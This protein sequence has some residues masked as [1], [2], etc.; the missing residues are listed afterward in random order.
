MPNHVQTAWPLTLAAALGD[1]SLARGLLHEGRSWLDRA[2]A[3]HPA[4]QRLRAA[5][6]RHLGALLYED[7]DL[8]HAEAVLGEAAEA[9]DAAGDATLRARIE[10]LLAYIRITLGGSNAAAFDQIQAARAVL[11]AAGDLAGLA[12]AWF[13][14]CHA[15]EGGSGDWAANEEAYQRALAYARQSGHHHV[16]VRASVYI[17]IVLS[18]APVRADQTIARL[19]QLLRDAGGDL[20]AEAHLLMILAGMYGYVARFADARAALAR[21]R[22]L[23]TGFGARYFLV[24]TTLIAGL[25]E[26]AA[27]DLPAAE[28]WFREGY[29]ALRAMADRA[30]LSLFASGLA[31]A[32]YAQGRFQEAWQMSEQAEATA[33]PDDF[34]P[35]A[36]WKIVRVKL[37]A[38][39]GQFPAARRLLG[40]VQAAL[41]PGEWPLLEAETLVAK[42]EIAR[43]AGAP[44][45]AEHHLRAALRIYQDF[46]LVAFAEK[47]KAAI[48][49]LT[50]T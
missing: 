22:A 45:E 9:A 13:F 28:R 42:A 10:V 33:G 2:L 18:N 16:A 36:R 32:L 38:Q 20:W 14:T 23:L 1:F 15:L 41:P 19:E 21:S 40:E 8:Q 50:Q 3:Q 34:D 17:G 29:E 43:L 39:R 35:Q 37:L 24:G 46:R 26:E 5:L 47:T 11:D 44:E 27:G 30:Y 25:T 7:G 6:L 12:E 49:S 4:D 31:E 48:A